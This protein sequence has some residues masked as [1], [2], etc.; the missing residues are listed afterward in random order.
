M[1]LVIIDLKGTL[2]ANGD[3]TSVIIRQTK[4]EDEIDD[5]LQAI[6]VI[7]RSYPADSLDIFVPIYPIVECED[8]LLEMVRSGIK[9]AVPYLEKLTGLRYYPVPTFIVDEY[10]ME[11]F[12]PIAP[13]DND[14]DELQHDIS[15][16]L[17]FF[18]AVCLTVHTGRF[19]P[20]D[21]DPQGNNYYARLSHWSHK[22]REIL[23]AACEGCVGVF[24]YLKGGSYW[25]GGLSIIPEMN[26]SPDFLGKIKIGLYEV[27]NILKEIHRNRV[28]DSLSHE[29]FNGRDFPDTSIWRRH[30]KDRFQKVSL[31]IDDRGMWKKELAAIIETFEITL[32][33]LINLLQEWSNS[34]SIWYGLMRELHTYGV[35][36]P[37]SSDN[38]RL[39]KLI[40]EKGFPSNLIPQRSGKVLLCVDRIKRRVKECASGKPFEEN[41]NEGMLPQIIAS[42][43]IHEHAHAITHEG[44][45][46]GEDQY[47]SN[48][49]CTGKKYKA[50]SETL[51]EWAEL[52]FFRDDP[53]L[54]D[55]VCQHAKSGFYPDWPYAGAIVLEES[56]TPPVLSIKYQVLMQCFRGD[57]NTAYRFLSLIK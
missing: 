46:A 41:L 16:I 4:E 23:V 44:I 25:F 51:A 45:G 10:T 49:S 7:P 29:Y 22:S 9:Q 40:N 34:R 52:N 11:S 38:T 32:P 50:V 48:P 47:F 36:F 30:L 15:E 54:F 24:D 19:L 42:T 56:L 18:Y 2:P 28:A 13:V 39:E 37:P 14:P 21:V 53:V 8:S 1:Q 3:T 55:I 12:V 6:P 20:L 17:R 31:N 43:L 35:Y 26:A 5:A 57:T 27:L 33:V